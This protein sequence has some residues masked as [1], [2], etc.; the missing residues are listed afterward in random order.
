MTGPDYPG[1]LADLAAEEAALDAVV[2]NLTELR[3][4]IPTPAAGW[5]VRDSVAHL[6]YSEDLARMAMKDP[7]EFG[8]RRQALVDAPDPGPLL[9]GAGRSMTG[10][11][12]LAW[13]REARADA[14]ELLAARGARDRLPWM[15]GPMSAMSFATARLME[16]WAHGQDVRDALGGEPAVSGRLRHIAD[17]GVRTRPFSYAARGLSVPDTDVRVEL[18]GPDLDRWVW[19]PEGVED[20][21]H[22]RALDFCLVVTQRL[23]PADTTLDVQGHAAQE[24]M[25]IAQ[26]FAGSATEQ[27]APR[28]R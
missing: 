7:D 10:P 1:L 25:G 21:V 16:T 20:V 9:V 5:D 18:V 15:E 2:A 23:H 4:A 14:L 3:W 13:W 26:A 19:G 24:W 6:A 11:A 12:V 27:R 8:R 28:Q 17:L 22:G